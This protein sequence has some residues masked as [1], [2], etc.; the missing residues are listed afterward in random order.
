MSCPDACQIGI[1]F[2]NNPATSE[3]ISE[4]TVRLGKIVPDSVVWN[5]ISPVVFTEW[6]VDSITYGSPD[7]PDPE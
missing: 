7:V 1:V 3:A 2:L 5:I 4:S 6:F